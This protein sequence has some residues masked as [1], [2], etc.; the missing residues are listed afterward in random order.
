MLISLT[1]PISRGKFFRDISKKSNDCLTV[2]TTLRLIY[3]LNFP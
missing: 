2:E 3:F 1:K